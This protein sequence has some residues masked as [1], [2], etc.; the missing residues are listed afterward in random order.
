MNDQTPDD[1]LPEL[2]GETITRMERA[3]F[4]EIAQDGRPARSRRTPLA[5]CV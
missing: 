2:S 4:A 5:P 3:V 1:A